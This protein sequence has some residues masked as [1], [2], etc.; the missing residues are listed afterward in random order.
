MRALY[1]GGVAAIALASA[2]LPAAADPLYFTPGD[3]VVAVE[4]NGSNT[5]ALG[6]SATGNTGASATSYLDNQAAPLTLYEFTTTGANQ[7]PVGTLELPTT[8]SGANSAISGEYGSSSEAT[9]QLSGNGQ[10]LTIAGYATNAAAYNAAYDVNGT[11]TALAQSCSLSVVANCAGVPQVARVIATISSSGA[12]DTSTVVYN[13]ANEN[14]PRSVYSS[15]GHSFYLSGQGT[16]NAGDSS[17]GVFFIPGTGP[18]QTPVAITGLDTT[19]KTISQDTR[20]VQIVNNTLVVSTDTKQGSNAARSFIGTLGSPPSTGLYSNGDG[21]TMLPGFGNTGGTGKQV[22]TTA[23]ANG[24]N[25]NGLQINLSPQ[26]YFFANATTLYVAD[27]GAPKQNSA[28]S[29]LGDGGLQNWSLVNGTWILDYTLSAGLN[30]VANS[31]AHG[32]SGL[33]GLTGQI[34]TV[35]GVQIVE[36]FATNYTLSDLD[37]TYLYGINDT[38]S[39]LTDGSLDGSFTMLAAA[40]AGTNFKGV[41]F[42]PVPEPTTIWLFGA[43]LAGVAFMGLR[44]KAKVGAAT[45]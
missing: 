34:V 26:G 1:L 44:R 16:G 13:V 19:N 25:A 11:G 45:A 5:A 38:L 33:F 40:P 20:D 31:S 41:S 27:D 22:I 37:P 7:T 14:N 17:G 2:T 43:G 21:P 35:N 15:D 30:L 3:L 32:T 28:T 4:G 42:A 18:N 36:L 9:L 12:V 29:S 10:Y 24:I 6:T 8:T 39:D 23:T